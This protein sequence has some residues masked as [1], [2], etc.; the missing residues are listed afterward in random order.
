M[1]HAVSS[2]LPVLISAW[3]PLQAQLEPGVYKASEVLEAGL[4]NYLL[5]VSADY[6]IHTV[7][8]SMVNGFLLLAVRIPPGRSA[9]VMKISGKP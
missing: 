7:Y 9:G 6:M 1:K 4:R 8:D 2:L 5:L 3:F